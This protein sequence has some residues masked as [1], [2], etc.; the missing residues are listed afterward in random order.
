MIRQNRQ[1]I[2]VNLINVQSRDQTKF[3]HHQT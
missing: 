3:P 1:Q 2:R